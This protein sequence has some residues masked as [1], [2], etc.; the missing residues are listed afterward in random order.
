MG[1]VLSSIES[2]SMKNQK[3][4]VFFANGEVLTTDKCTDV[5]V[6]LYGESE[7]GRYCKM[8]YRDKPSDLSRS[9][10]MKKINYSILGCAVCKEAVCDDCWEKGYDKHR[11]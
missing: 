1:F 11:K 7:S 6:K 8:C 2:V 4:E 10:K 9:Q 5:R 3:K